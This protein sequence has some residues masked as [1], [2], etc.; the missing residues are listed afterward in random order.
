MAMEVITHNRA[1]HDGLSHALYTNEKLE[2]E[3]LTKWLSH[4]KVCVCV[5]AP[6]LEC[7][8]CYVCGCWVV[9]M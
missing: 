8:E 7:V 1:I 4:V 5:H 2:G 9:S 3:P 6:A